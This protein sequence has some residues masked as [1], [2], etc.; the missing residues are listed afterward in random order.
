V[1][2][3]AD[4]LIDAGEAMATLGETAQ[5]AEWLRQALA[6]AEAKE[7]RPLSAQLRRRLDE[8]NAGRGGS[9]R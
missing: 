9:P 7:H 3:K 4:A 8:V 6:V 1:H 2:V 5:A